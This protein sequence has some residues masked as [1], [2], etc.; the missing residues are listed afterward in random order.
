M[1]DTPRTDKE[2]ERTNND[3]YL[4]GYVDAEFARQLERDLPCTNGE[5]PLVVH[6]ALMV[7]LNHIEPGWENSREIVKQW[8]DSLPKPSTAANE[9]KDG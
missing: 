9:R 4:D 6:M 2:C 7:L 8:H 1:S 3:Y 5:V